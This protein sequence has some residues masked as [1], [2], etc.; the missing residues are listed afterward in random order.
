VG[1]T[2]GEKLME[3]LHANETKA[4]LER[5]EYLWGQEILDHRDLVLAQK[6]VAFHEETKQKRLGNVRD[7]SEA[8]QYLQRLKTAPPFSGRDATRVAHNQKAK[9]QRQQAREKA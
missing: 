3:P 6:L 9:A 1:G 7:T 5:M 2:G 8:G 4:F